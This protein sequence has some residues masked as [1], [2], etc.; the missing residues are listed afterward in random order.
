MATIPCPS[1]REPVA[2]EAEHCPHCGRPT[3]LLRLLATD[4]P[5]VALLMAAAALSFLGYCCW[6]YQH[7]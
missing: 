2:V 7:P 6:C 3:S 4:H 1:C 5:R